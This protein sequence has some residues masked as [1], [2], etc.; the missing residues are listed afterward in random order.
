MLARRLIVT[1]FAI[2]FIVLPSAIG[3][4]DERPDTHGMILI[5]MICAGMRHADPNNDFNLK[6]CQSLSAAGKIAPAPRSR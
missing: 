2:E 3:F 6:T 4:P 1:L 5:E